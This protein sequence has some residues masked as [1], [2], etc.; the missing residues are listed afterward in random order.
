MT[1]NRLSRWAVPAAVVLMISLSSGIASARTV[2]PLPSKRSW[3]PSREY[4]RAG[5][6]TLWAKQVFLGGP[7]SFPKD[8][9]IYSPRP[10]ELRARA[11]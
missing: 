2:G 8:R 7:I 6:T 11:R 4:L 3:S 9:F 10:S 5:L 1:L